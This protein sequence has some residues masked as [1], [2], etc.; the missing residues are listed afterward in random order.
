MY[1]VQTTRQPE[2]PQLV[3]AD[4]RLRQ[5]ITAAAAQDGRGHLVLAPTHAVV[6][7]GMVEGYGSIGRVRVF[8]AW[9]H[10]EKISP[11]E[12][13][14]LWRA[15]EKLLAGAGEVIVPCGLE[16]PL[17]PLLARMGYQEVMTAKLF[18]KEF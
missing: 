7:G 18:R 17:L 6:R 14:A 13:L 8:H 9:L 3:R 15:A 5:A 2:R 1:T 16:S 10:S 4:A 11:R 12:T